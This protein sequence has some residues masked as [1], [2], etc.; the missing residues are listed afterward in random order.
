MTP[1]EKAKVNR[2]QNH[3]S[4]DIYHEKHDRQHR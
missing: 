3:L 2:Q 4:R 1:A